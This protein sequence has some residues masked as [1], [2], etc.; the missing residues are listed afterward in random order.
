MGIALARKEDRRGVTLIVGASLAADVAWCLFTLLG[1]EGG[2][3]L[4]SQALHSPRLPWSHSLLST[5]VLAGAYALA[6]APRPRLM[7]LAA[8]AVGLHWLLGDVPFGE[9]FPIFPWS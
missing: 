1:M 4:G 3:S 7:G 2:R 8:A 9:A 6:A 5:A